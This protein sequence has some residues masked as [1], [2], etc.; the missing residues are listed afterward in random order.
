[1]EASSTVPLS[2]RQRSVVWFLKYG[3]ANY[4]PGSWANAM[5]LANAEDRKLPSDTYWNA[6]GE[7]ARQRL[8]ANGY[9]DSFRNR[10]EG[11]QDRANNRER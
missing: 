2:L 1:M 11:E 4:I 5:L 8:I 6:I 3:Y 9:D 7:R 10:S